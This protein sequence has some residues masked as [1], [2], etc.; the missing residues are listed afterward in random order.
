MNACL[1]QSLKFPWVRESA[2][3]RA[4]GAGARRS[5]TATPAIG[6]PAVSCSAWI[7]IGRL[8]LC[9]ATL[10]VAVKAGEGGRI[11]APPGGD[12]QGEERD[13]WRIENRCGI[14]SLYVFIHLIGKPISYDEILRNV[15]VR[16]SGTSLAELKSFLSERK[17]ACAII[18]CTPDNLRRQPLPAIAYTSAG[19]E[20]G[21]FS[22]IASVDGRTLRLVDGTAGSVSSVAIEQFLKS[23]EG[24]LL[25]PVEERGLASLLW[26]AVSIL[27]IVLVAQ[28]IVGP[29]LAR[30]TRRAPRITQLQE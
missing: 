1:L 21:H 10:S 18:R 20:R 28:S 3:S 6:P 8:L 22:V 24:Y 29:L 30:R 25:V 9:V 11:A 26:A 17:I 13:L 7:I 12:E 27:G 15:P 16:E 23:W 2:G 5:T 19:A 4:C 14:N